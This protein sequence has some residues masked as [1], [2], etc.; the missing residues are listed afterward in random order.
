MTKN[1][2]LDHFINGDNPFREEWLS[3][4]DLKKR[5]N[6]APY[7]VKYQLNWEELVKLRKNGWKFND[8]RRYT[9]SDISLSA[10]SNNINK[11]IMS[12]KY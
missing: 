1:Y 10:L 5:Y 4:Q 6:I 2:P 3:K 12:G 9:N 8:I 7:R 11:L